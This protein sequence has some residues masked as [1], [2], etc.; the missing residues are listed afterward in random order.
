MDVELFQED[1]FGDLAPVSGSTPAGVPW[2]HV[3]FLPRPLGLESPQLDAASYRRVAEAR[4]SLA[5]LDATASRLLNPRMFRTASLRLEAQATAALEGTY[6]P[7]ERVLAADDDDTSDPDLLEVLNY[8]AVARQAFSWSEQ[9][10][11]WGVRDLSELQALLVRGT[12]TEREYSGQVRPIQV[13]IG[14]RE[15]AS[16]GELPIKAARYVP[17]P[18]GP[19]LEARLRDV[20][21][22]MQADHSE[23]IDPIVAAAMGHYAFEAAHPFHDG[24]GRIG[25]LL[26]VMQ[27]LASRTLTEPTL[28]VSPWFEARRTEYYDALFGVSAR[29][30][31]S[32]WVSFF[33]RGLGESADATRARML[34]LVSVQADLKERLQSTPIRTANARILIDYAVGHATFTVGQAAAALGMSHAGAKKL[35]D[36]M[37]THGLLAPWGKRNY[38]RQ[39]HAPEV[40]RTL[41][42]G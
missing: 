34:A 21:D 8:L 2:Q 10:R 12:A 33:A 3:A 40:M 26:I 20:S 25:R 17:P 37:V 35:I 38:N 16:P 22:W 5:A 14:R 41:L 7:L 6:V 18:P 42:Q 39:F 28:T 29:S 4:A 13:V 15:S 31:W 19:D 23:A 9:G 11:G 36:S 32:T 1:A 30:D 27:L 24:N